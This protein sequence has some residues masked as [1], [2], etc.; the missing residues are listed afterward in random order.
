MKYGQAQCIVQ[1]KLGYTKEIALRQF[2]KIESYLNAMKYA[3]P[4]GTYLIETEP[5]LYLPKHSRGPQFR[6]LYVAWGATKY[7]WKH[8][9]Y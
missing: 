6:R 2:T 4:D 1:K 8:S 3:D 7:F 5:C 9:R